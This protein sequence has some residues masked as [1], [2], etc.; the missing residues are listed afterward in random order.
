MSDEKEIRIN[1]EI[2]KG[3]DGGLYEILS[4][5]FEG[6]SLRQ[7][8]AVL[9]RE[10]HFIVR[11]REGHPISRLSDIPLTQQEQAGKKT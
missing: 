9:R 2:V 3:R 1:L 5:L 7:R 4:K 10:M 6:V 8:A 11:S